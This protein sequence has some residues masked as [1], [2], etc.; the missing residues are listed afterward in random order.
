MKYCKFYIPN[1]NYEEVVNNYI[2]SKIEEYKNLYL[3][4]GYTIELY[5]KTDKNG[6]IIL[7]KCNNNVFINMLTG[8][9]Q[10]HAYC[11]DDFDTFGYKALAGGA[12]GK[13]IK[14]DAELLFS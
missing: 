8:F 11:Y 9:I 4:K 13:P 1:T 10:Y 2:L 6:C 5:K 14:T 3:S 7:L 12:E